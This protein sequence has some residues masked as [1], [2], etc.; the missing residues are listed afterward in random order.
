MTE[1]PI[2]TTNTEERPHAE[3]SSSQL[4]SL[5]LCPGYRPRQETKKHWVTKQ[6]ERGHKAL[7]TED[8]E[9]LESNFE[10]RMVALCEDYIARNIPA[11]YKEEKEVRV[12]TIEARWGYVDLRTFVHHDVAYIVDYKFVK[13]KEVTDAE[14]NL[15]G[16]DYVIGTFD[17]NPEVNTIHVH[18]LMP[19]FES[20]TTATF[21]R[22][23]LPALKLEVL[24]ILA[25]AKKTDST[26][27][28]GASLTPNYEVCR[29]CALLGTPKCRPTW[30]IA[31]A[32]GRAYDPDG[33]GKLPPVPAETHASDVKDPKILGQ[34]RTLAGVME[35]WAKA[36][37][38]HCVTAALEEGLTAEGFK[39]DWRKGK[40]K[41]TKPTELLLVANEFGLTTQDL[42]D[43]S[44]ISV[45][46]LEAILRDRA[47]KGQKDKA[48]NAFLDRLRDLDALDRNEETP[49]LV[50]I[51]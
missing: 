34:L 14:I 39:L 22:D 19:R 28:R 48:V 51:Q 9:D 20:V 44:T 2:P 15:Q 5:A 1:Q 42:I 32:I 35:P 13:A 36:A 10:E 12:E 27:Y 18:F 17:A 45:S 11:G 8:T 33:Y 30:K 24:C 46:K 37:N 47:S 21:T 49:T 4:G 29:F 6:G 41:I 40:R 43:S 23:Q 16:K 38:H 50:R 31:D 7:E 26:R 25:R 3:R